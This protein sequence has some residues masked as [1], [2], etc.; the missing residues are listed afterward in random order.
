M[1]M[2]IQD[3]II[4]HWTSDA[5][6][7]FTAKAKQG[8]RAVSVEQLNAFGYL[9]EHAYDLCLTEM[10]NVL[11][12]PGFESFGLLFNGNSGTAQSQGD[13]THNNIYGEEEEIR[14]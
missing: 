3:G 5:M 7:Y 8:N 14:M 1:N 9:A 2:L 10:D 13:G 6:D 4:L 12:N 11:E